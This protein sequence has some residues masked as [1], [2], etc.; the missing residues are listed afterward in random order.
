MNHVLERALKIAEAMQAVGFALWQLQSLEETA[1]TWVVVRLHAS[2]GMG[3]EAGVELSKKP[4]R[5]TLG[6][7][8]K[9]LREAGVVPAELAEELLAVL[10]L[11]NW[12]VHRAR[13]EFHGMLTSDELLISL[14][15]KVSAIASRALAAQKSAAAE[16]EQFVLS[17][18]VSK[19]TIDREASALAK[20]WG[21][22]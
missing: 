10:E 16:L 14:H 20:E 9:E 12:L 5:R 4:E 19:E 1:V 3:R 8:L 22:E 2:R 15:S 6:S 17:S 13:K 11:R 21:L 7:V 18:G